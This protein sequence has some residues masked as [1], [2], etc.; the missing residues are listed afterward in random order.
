MRMVLDALVPIFSLV[1]LGY[2]LRH[3]FL[4]QPA[5]WQGTSKLVYFLLLPALLINR[6]AT[7]A[8]DLRVVTPMWLVLI[9]TMLVT[10][11]LAFLLWPR[12]ALRGPGFTSLLQGSIRPNTYT[13]L[14]LVAALHGDGGLAYAAIALAGM[15]PLA[16]VLSVSALVRYGELH[17]LAMAT[18]KVVAPWRSLLFSLVRNPLILACVVGIGANLSGLGM[19]RDGGNVLRVLA[20]A[21]LPIGLLTVGAGLRPNRLHHAPV[22]LLLATLLKLFLSPL[23][24]WLLCLLIDA[25]SLVRAVSVLFVAIPCATSS[26]ILAEQMGGDR[27]LM[28]GILT[29]ET[30]V[31]AVTLPVWLLVLG[32]G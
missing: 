31:A 19:P 9:T 16:N 5:F 20:Q 4:I 14:A 8:L 21:A 11:V 30:L 23:L 17:H 10:A 13:G 25:D 26:Y 2:G 7:S 3:W 27:E 32:M 28:A 12:R 6:L 24:A 15:V 29:V 22:P 18:A 1:L